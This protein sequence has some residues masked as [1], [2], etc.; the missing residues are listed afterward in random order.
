MHMT[1][2]LVRLDDQRFFIASRLAALQQW[3]MDDLA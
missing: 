2:T 1:V 3:A